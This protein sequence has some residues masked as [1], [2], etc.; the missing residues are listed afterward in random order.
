MGKNEEI[1]AEQVEET[2]AQDVEDDTPNPFGDYDYDDTDASDDE[3]AD[4]EGVESEAA[5]STGEDDE[6]TAPEAS[7]PAGDRV[8]KVKP[9][10]DEPEVDTKPSGRAVDRELADL[11]HK[12]GLD[13]S[14]IKAFKDAESLERFLVK[15]VRQEPSAQPEAPADE[16]AYELDLPAELRENLEPGLVKA[17]EGLNSHYGEQVKALKTQL[18]QVTDHL[19]YQERV[20]DV[21]RFDKAIAK[22]GEEFGEIFGDGESLS[23][24]ADDPQLLNRNKVFEAIIRQREAFT[25]KGQRPPAWDELARREAF[26]EFGEQV[27]EAR[28]KKTRDEI[29]K[30]LSG[31]HGA[32]AG[33]PTAG[34]TRD[35]PLG[36]ERAIRNLE[37]Q[38]RQR[39]IRD[40]EYA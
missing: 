40:D 28:S 19:V 3:A 32:I 35:L 22:L 23:M 29:R 14:D 10:S 18:K 8:G 30:G 21:G 2:E 38:L 36:E 15:R 24:P 7:K 13:D 6:E 4:D 33:R 20:A 37:S 5:E 1:V 26:A 17:V 12:A 31:R 25:R 16:P 27:A 39:G 11:A 34:R 9:K